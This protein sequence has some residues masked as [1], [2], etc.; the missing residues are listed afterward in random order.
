MQRRAQLTICMPR[1]GLTI[2]GKDGILTKKK[3]WVSTYQQS[4]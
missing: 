2:H 3:H 1:K 4:G